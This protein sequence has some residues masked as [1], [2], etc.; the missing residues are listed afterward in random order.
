MS[1]RR[2]NIYLILLILIF[3]FH[4]ANNYFWL[5]N[6]N[7]VKG[8]D[9]QIH[10][11]SSIEFFYRLS[12]VI[13]SSTVHFWTK[14]VDIIEL[15][16]RPIHPNIDWPNFVNLCASFFYFIFGRSLLAAKLTMLP[17][18]LIL[19]VS[20]YSIGKKIANRFVGL[21]AAFTVSMYPIIFESTRQYA[22][23]FPLT[24]MVAL[25]ILFLLQCDSFKNRKYAILLG[26]A[27]G[28]GMLVKG[29][30]V[31]FIIMP[32][33]LVLFNTSK[34]IFSSFRNPSELAPKIS[35]YTKII[36]NIGFFIIIAALISSI[37][38]GNKLFQVVVA[39]RE[40]TVN[41]LLIYQGLLK[42]EDYSRAY[43]YS[44]HSVEIAKNSVGPFLFLIFSIAFIFF[45]KAKVKYKGILVGWISFPFLLCS[46]IFLAKQGRFLMPLLPGLALISAWGVSQ[47]KGRRFK[48]L[49]L[50]II[51]VF[52]LTQFFIL[53]Y[54]TKDYRYTVTEKKKIFGSSTYGRDSYYKNF[55][56]F[57]IDEIV[58][59]IRERSAGKEQIKV[60]SIVFDRH[61]PGS[62]ELVYWLKLKDRFI[63]PI[64]LKEMHGYFLRDF[65]SLDFI[66][67]RPPRYST[68]VWPKGERFRQEFKNRYSIKWLE[69][70]SDPR[71]FK[72]LD[73]LENS[74]SEFEFIKKIE[75]ENGFRCYIYKRR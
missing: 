18:F 4:L 44:R 23:D 72:L 54:S 41:P 63:D 53:S 51:V 31:L 56:D 46:F 10:L 15:L 24:A 65:D 11:F 67:F 21:C 33:C 47:I 74:Q 9:V 22:L 58:K 43:L 57:K 7:S 26:F 8:V 69:I 35:S 16:N 52:G 75:R 38:W 25:T 40:Q 17:F 27:F 12:D 19:I 70:Q 32:L 73:K 64:D 45:I 55:N 2:I 49:S 6:N 30:L 34:Q 20:T 29:Q 68:F 37:W 61:R 66:L 13:F 60:G 59:V 71:W 1:K 5:K 42:V 50:G 14:L 36:C 28:I 48:H 3:C 62:L 39:L